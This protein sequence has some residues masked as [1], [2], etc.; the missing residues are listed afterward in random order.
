MMR[1]NPRTYTG[2]STFKALMPLSIT[3]FFIQ[4]Q[5]MDGVLTHLS[6]EENEEQSFTPSE[7]DKKLARN[8]MSSLF[9]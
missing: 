9:T 2:A 8:N 1:E 4:E 3:D 5:F 7:D 6:D